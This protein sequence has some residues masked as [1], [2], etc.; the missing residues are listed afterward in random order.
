MSLEHQEELRRLNSRFAQ[1]FVGF[2]HA[3]DQ[4]AKLCGRRATRYVIARGGSIITTGRPIYVGERYIYVGE[5]SL[6]DQR[7]SKGAKGS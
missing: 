2:Q 5:R 6:G 7:E 1:V 3:Q 4:H